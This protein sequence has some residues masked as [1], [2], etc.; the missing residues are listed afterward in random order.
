MAKGSDRTSPMI[1]SVA[2]LLRR[3]GSHRAISLQVDLD[4]LTTSD[5][6]V[7]G[8]VH[9]QLHLESGISGLEVSGSLA[10][11][12]RG[13]CRRCLE[14]I[15]QKVEQELREMYSSAPTDEDTYPIQDGELDLT[16]M[17]R[18]CLVLALPIAPLCSEEC[19]GPAPDA[20]PMNQP[21]TP[22]EERP[23]DPR[24]AALDAL[25]TGQ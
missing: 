12:W 5:A 21:E 22:A 20:Y 16:P 2:E 4:D 19:A 10:A 18:D 15:E 23:K 6:A 13:S 8:P 9:L 1:V 25:R 7:H 24:W 11:G 3:P 17:V 14:P